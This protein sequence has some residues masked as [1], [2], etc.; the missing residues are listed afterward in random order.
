MLGSLATRWLLERLMLSLFDVWRLGVQ[1]GGLSRCVLAVSVS[2]LD[3][4]SMFCA[5]GCNLVVFPSQTELGLAES[6]HRPTASSPTSDPP[7]DRPY[8]P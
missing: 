5:Y 7:T 6:L 2:V 4:P 8:T 1:S 3:F